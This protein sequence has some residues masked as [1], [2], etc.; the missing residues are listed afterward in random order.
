M[1]LDAGPAHSRLVEANVWL[2]TH[3]YVKYTD[4]FGSTHESRF[5]YRYDTAFNEF[6]IDLTVSPEYHRHT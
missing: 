1:E 6:R 5:C 2:E 3:D 4:S